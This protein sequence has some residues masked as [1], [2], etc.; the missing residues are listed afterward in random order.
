MGSNGAPVP[1]ELRRDR[2]ALIVVDMQNDFVRVG[3]PLEVPDARETI[4]VNQELLAWFRGHSRPIVF[5]RFVAGPE[6]TLMWKWSAVIAP[7]TCCCWPGFM[8]SYADI[9]GERECI[10]VI[11]ELEPLP[12]EHQVD[13]YGYNAFHRTRLTDLLHAAGIDTV[14]ISGTVT[15][16]CV[17]DTA[18]GA[19]HEGFQAAVVADAVSSYAPELHRASL[20]TLAMKYG[21]VVSA[22]DALKEMA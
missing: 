5:T 13:K 7:P 20:Q 9:E 19:F 10:A 14:L 15:Q 16:I 4:E 8:R 11:D 2:S 12:G 3:A 6:P 1:F 22:H 18:R 21:R 17:E